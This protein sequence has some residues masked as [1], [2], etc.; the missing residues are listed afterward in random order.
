[1]VQKSG[2][3]LNKMRLK[4][5]F[6]PQFGELE[7]YFNLYGSLRLVL[8]FSAS[9]KNLF[10]MKCTFSLLEIAMPYLHLEQLRCSFRGHILKIIDILVLQDIFKNV[11]IVRDH[12]VQFLHLSKKHFTFLVYKFHRE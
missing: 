8:M 3:L 10:F 11:Y 5:A 9:S 2:I 7:A 12:N 4:Y 6:V 1:M